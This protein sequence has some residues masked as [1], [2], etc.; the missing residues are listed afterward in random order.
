MRQ[1]LNN[2]GMLLSELSK[3]GGMFYNNRRFQESVGE[4]LGLSFS[5]V[6]DLI[7]EMKADGL[8]FTEIHGKYGVNPQV[9]KFFKST[10]KGL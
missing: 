1:L 5:R 10:H 3:R 2:K 4:E 6:R 9:M 7:S 8:V